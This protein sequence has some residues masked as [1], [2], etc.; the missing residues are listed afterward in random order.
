MSQA[1][2]RCD[3]CQ[4]MRKSYD[5]HPV[6]ENGR[7]LLACNATSGCRNVRRTMRRVARD[8]SWDLCGTSSPKD[9]SLY[10]IKLALAPGYGHDGPHADI[11]GRTWPWAPTPTKETSV[12]TTKTLG[13]V[14]LAYTNPDGGP[15]K[16]ADAVGA[17]LQKALEERFGGEVVPANLDGLCV[18]VVFEKDVSDGQTLFSLEVG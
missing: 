15:R 6:F 5:L 10:C 1:K 12:S 7:H 18:T 3:R 9:P 17:R 11:Y 2:Q 4:R 8:V 16:A 14:D 13:R